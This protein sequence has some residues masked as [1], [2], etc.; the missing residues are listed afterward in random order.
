MRLMQTKN[1]HTHTHSKEEKEKK[2]CHWHSYRNSLIH[3]VL[4]Q[5]LLTPWLAVVMSVSCQMV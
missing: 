5:V 1:I 2:A 3:C 4:D